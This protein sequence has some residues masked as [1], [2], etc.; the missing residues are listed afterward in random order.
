[1]GVDADQGWIK[2][3]LIIASMMKGVDVGVYTA[4]KKALDYYA[5]KV[6]VLWWCSRAR[7]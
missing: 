6:S 3:R 4:V 7:T 2:S 1:M 5:V